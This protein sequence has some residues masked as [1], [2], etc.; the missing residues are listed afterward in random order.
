MRSLEGKT[1][2][3]TGATKGIGNGLAHTLAARGANIIVVSRTPEDCKRVAEEMAAR[4]EVKACPC[5]ADVTDLSQIEKLMERAEKEFGTIDIMVNNAGSAITKR[6]EDL[7]EADWDRVLN[8]DLKAVFFCAQAAGRRMIHQQSGK[9][10]N[11][12][13]IFGLVGDKQVLPYCVAKGGVVQMTRALALEWAK[14][15]IQVNA[16]CPGY[17]ITDMNKQDLQDERISK[18]ILQKVAMRRYGSVEELQG[19]CVF[20]A[21]EASNYM[22]GQT[23]V[24]DGGWTCE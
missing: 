23:L 13:S 21:S 18:H 19:A 15:N 5:P 11:V 2:V 24:L 10:I 1:A 16:L 7:T 14:Y 22:T 20:L 9:I 8:I 3:V 17:V 4:Y 12:A 6:A